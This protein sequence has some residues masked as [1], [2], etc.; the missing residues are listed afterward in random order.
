MV[1]SEFHSTFTDSSSVVDSG[2]ALARIG[3]P[4][5]TLLCACHQVVA[6]PQTVVLRCSSFF[7]SLLRPPLVA[8]GVQLSEDY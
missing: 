4:L 3:A 6:I 7:V 8:V 2:L 1:H 5:I